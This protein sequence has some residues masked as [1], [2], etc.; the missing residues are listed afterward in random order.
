MASGIESFLQGI[1]VVDLSRHLPGPLTTLLLADMGAR[2]IK[3]EPPDGDDMR[4]ITP[5]GP[6][7]RSPAFD[8]LNAGKTSLRIDLK[9]DAGRAELLE[10]TD[11]ADIVV[12]S[13]RPGVLD[14]LGV[15]F[16]SMRVRNR[17]LICCAM[18][19][20]GSTGEMAR[21]PGHDINFLAMA[22]LL[23]YS[24]NAY[25]PTIPTPPLADFTASFVALSAILGALHRRA[26]DGMGC[27]IDLAIADCVMVPQVMQLAELR[28]GATG[29]RRGAEYNTGA[30]AYYN[31]YVTSD[32]GMVALGAM[33]E[34]F[35]RSFCTAAGRDDWAARHNDPLPQTDLVA[36]VAAMFASMSRA[37]A[38]A[39]FGHAQCCFTPVNS[40]PEA[41]LEPQVAARSL[42]HTG[43]D[44]ILQAL[45]PVHV[46]NQ[47]PKLRPPF[48][49]MPRDAAGT[50]ISP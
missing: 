19:G 35:W 10:L 31:L 16:A 26:R 7:G 44:G 29:P 42:V 38:V 41:V 8:A 14:R 37:D 50:H 22:G 13:F 36:E 21:Q 32:G 24:G 43:E 17:G 48:R 11:A 39:R 1:S 30:A 27:E 23:S 6:S 25:A 12:E 33:E 9:T 20:Y 46:N 28:D 40:L 15:G 34:R 4:W 2:I 3:V 45:F 49:E 18:S 5:A 47:P